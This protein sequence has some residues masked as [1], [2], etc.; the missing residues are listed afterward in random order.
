ML[1]KQ[2]NNQTGW[3]YT[4]CAGQNR[5]YDGVEKDVDYDDG[6]ENYDWN[7]TR[8]IL[9]EGEDPTKWLQ[10]S[11]KA[12]DEQETE[13]ANLDLSQVCPLSLNENQKA[14][15]SLL[16]HT[17]YN[18]VENTEQLELL[19]QESRMLSSVSRG[20]GGKS[21]KPMMQYR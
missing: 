20:Q 4:V 9:P 6:G 21:L 7:S 16:L 2:G 1:L 19:V 11:I 15:V 3:M 5:I 18:F 10:E 8:I 13:S 17:L 12:D 14:I